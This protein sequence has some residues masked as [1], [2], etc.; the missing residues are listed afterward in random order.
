MITRSAVQ[1]F[2]FKRLIVMQTSF[3]INSMVI[4]VA[5]KEFQYHSI[6]DGKNAL[7]RAHEE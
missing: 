1:T 3:P 7:Q 6:R 2:I 5:F 4:F